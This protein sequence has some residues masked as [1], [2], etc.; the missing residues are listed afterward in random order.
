MQKISNWSSKHRIPA[1]FGRSGFAFLHSQYQSNHAKR[2]A[3]GLEKKKSGACG[4]GALL[5]GRTIVAQQTRWSA[6]KITEEWAR[7]WVT[8]KFNILRWQ[9]MTSTPGSTVPTFRPCNARFGF[10][11]LPIEE[12]LKPFM[13]LSAAFKSCL[14]WDHF[15]TLG[16]YLKNK[17]KFS[18]E[19]KERQ[20]HWR[21]W[22]WWS[23]QDFPAWWPSPA[24]NKAWRLQNFD[25]RNLASCRVSIAAWLAIRHRL[26]ANQAY[27]THR[28]TGHLS[29]HLPLVLLVIRQISRQNGIEK[30]LGSSL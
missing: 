5:C 20:K 23:A 25:G 16:H 7:N 1:R 3:W 19:T 30:K 14:F 29:R 27:H 11:D 6:P 8:G 24:P 17:K 13:G 28:R 18:I 15:G 9:T 4:G 2:C 12:F 21:E 26:L 22:I 10:Q